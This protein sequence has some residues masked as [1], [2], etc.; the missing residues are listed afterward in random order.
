MNQSSRKRGEVLPPLN[1]LI[2]IAHKAKPTVNRA[3][4]ERGRIQSVS[5][6]ATRLNIREIKE[7]ILDVES[8]IP[9]VWTK[10]G[11]DTH[12]KTQYIHRPYH[13]KLGIGNMCFIYSDDAVENVYEFPI[14]HRSGS[15][16]KRALHSVWKQLGV[17]PSRVIRCVLARL[18]G[19]VTIPTHHDTGRWVTVAHRM[20]VPVVTNRGVHFYAGVDSGHMSKYHFSEGSAVEL[21]NHAKHAV[22][23]ESDC[24]RIH[25]M[26]DYLDEKAALCPT[27]KRVVLSEDQKIVRHRRYIEILETESKIV[28]DDADDDGDEDSNTLGR[29][30]SPLPLCPPVAWSDVKTFFVIGVQKCGTSS[31]YDYICQHPKVRRAKRKETHFFDWQWDDVLAS[32]DR[33]D[34]L[35]KGDALGRLCSAVGGGAS[36]CAAARPFDVAMRRAWCEQCLDVESIVSDRTLATGEATPSYCLYGE[37]VARRIKAIVPHARLIMTVRDPC[38]R[39]WSQFQ[40]MTGGDCERPTLRN[41]RSGAVGRTHAH[42][43]FRSVALEEIAK[44]RQSG[45]G[46]DGDVDLGAFQEKYLSQRPLKHGAHSYIGRGLYAAQAKMWLKY[47]DP[48]QLLFVALDDMR[49]YE[50]VQQQTRRVFKHIGLPPMTVADSSHK[51]KRHYRPIPPRVRENL[52][53]FYAKHNADLSE[54]MRSHAKNASCAI[55]VES[56]SESSGVP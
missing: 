39:A 16:W 15:K 43:G 46:H 1:G 27:P 47:F 2:S 33:G 25:L 11:H 10:E 24:A 37:S 54:L 29:L 13:E 31:L 6:H 20:H 30:S 21:N 5:T 52:G 35:T 18:P 4:E 42:L 34:S 7:L 44:L 22:S 36:G 9:S 32:I 40:M 19:N 41:G 48:E 55:A 50:G 45:I 53:N 26:F 14:Y 17:D 51:N 28:G 8:M 12:L 23:N 38:L 56:W 3:P 49:T